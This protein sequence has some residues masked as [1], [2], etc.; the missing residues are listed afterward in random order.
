[1]E[2]NVRTSSSA[3]QVRDGD[4]DVHGDELHAQQ[5]VRRRVVGHVVG[6]HHGE[7][8]CQRAAKQDTQ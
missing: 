3:V 5:P 1:M 6:V 2:S 7:R 8:Q 4:D